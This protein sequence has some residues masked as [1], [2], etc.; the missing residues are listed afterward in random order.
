MAILIHVIIFQLQNESPAIE[1]KQ[2]IIQDFKSQV[3]Q[4]QSEGTDSDSSMKKKSQETS[5]INTGQGDIP[6]KE[7]IPATTNSQIHSDNIERDSVKHIEHSKTVIEDITAEPS[8]NKQATIIT[9]EKGSAANGNNQKVGQLQGK[10]KTASDSSTLDKVQDTDNS[11]DKSTNLKSDMNNKPDANK[12]TERKFYSVNNEV[13][14]DVACSLNAASTSNRQQ[15]DAQNFEPVSLSQLPDS[16][17]VPS[18]ASAAKTKNSNGK[19]LKY[20]IWRVRI[21]WGIS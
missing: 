15:D 16:S 21:E 12:T 19:L 17:T 7:K 5:I 18:F 11:C 8:P 1:T 13:P 2:H 6:D 9:L 20:I 4:A 3:L 14:K 10:S